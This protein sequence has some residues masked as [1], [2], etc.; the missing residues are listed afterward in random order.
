MRS[1]EWTHYA[2]RTWTPRRRPAR[3]VRSR[4]PATLRAT[5]S[6]RRTAPPA[7]LSRPWRL[8]VTSALIT[9]CLLVVGREPGITSALAE[10]W[11]N[12]RMQTLGWIMDP[13]APPAP[14]PAHRR[15]RDTDGGFRNLRPVAALVDRGVFLLESDGDL[16]AAPSDG[17]A[18][19]LPVVTGVTVQEVPGEFGLD[20][21]AEF[22]MATL[23]KILAQPFIGRVSEIHVEGDGGIR[24]YL[25][26]MTVVRLQSSPGL[27]RELDR[28]A[29]VLADIRVKGKRIAVVDMRYPDH[30]VVRPRPGR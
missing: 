21:E 19:D 30:V 1:A 8:I 26:D 24:L 5:V 27:D 23:R 22:D 12:V 6:A 2:G 4:P 7:G 28:L 3:R 13:A 25:R 16:H 9:I 17:S 15:T 29:A 10:Q 14:P 20:L 11:H 18:G